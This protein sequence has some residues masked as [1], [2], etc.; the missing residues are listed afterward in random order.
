MSDKEKIAQNHV[1]D[2]S[3]PVENLLRQLHGQIKSSDWL[4]ENS[5]QKLENENPELI[6]SWKEAIDSENS[7]K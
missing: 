6:K 2:E 7:K 5:A 3:D 1:Q 4:K